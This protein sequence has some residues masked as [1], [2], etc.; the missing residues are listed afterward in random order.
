MGKSRNFPKRVYIKTKT[1][2]F[3]GLNVVRISEGYLSCTHCSGSFIHWENKPCVYNGWGC[4]GKQWRRAENRA[5]GS[6]Y[7]A[8]QAGIR[9]G[10]A[11]WEANRTSYLSF[12]WLLLGWLWK[13]SR[14]NLTIFHLFFITPWADWCLAVL[15]ILLSLRISKDRIF[16]MQYHLESWIL[17]KQEENKLKPP[18]VQVT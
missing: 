7:T 9:E 13:N 18:H 5:V 2:N 14:M 4:A 1:N 11:A 6:D 17:V 16:H 8:K 3:V 15:Q 12:T 10:R